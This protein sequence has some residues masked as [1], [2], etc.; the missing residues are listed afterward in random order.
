MRI[1]NNMLL[2]TVLQNLTRAQGRYL[3]IQTMASSGKRINKASDDPIGVTKDLAY[4]SSLTTI[5]Q[6]NKN[7]DQGK[8]WLTF[9]DQALGNINELLSSAKE[10]MVQMGNDTYDA[11]ARRSAAVEIEGILQ[12][13]TE[14]AN[15]QYEG[16]YIFSGSSTT[17]PPI[18]LSAIGAVYQG[19]NTNINLETEPS[20]YLRINS[21]AADFLLKAVRTLGDGFDLNAGI[22][23]NLWLSNLHGGE[24]VDMGAGIFNISTLNG[25]YNIDVSAARN[26]QDILN[27]VNNAGIPN[28]HIS[29][30][31]AQNGFTIEDTSVHQLTLNT[32]LSLLNMGRGVDQTQGLIRFAVGAGLTVDVDISAANTV[33]DVINAINTQLPAGGINNVTAALDPATNSLTI[34]DANAAPL[35][36]NISEAST[37]AHTASDLGILGDVFGTLTGKEIKTFQM[38]VTENG[39]D[40]NT[41]KTLGIQKGTEYGILNGDDL[42]SELT[43]FTKLSTLKGGQGLDLGK[44]RIVNG[45][46]F[47]DIDFAALCND[48]SATISDVLQLINSSGIN[49][50]ARINDQHTGISLFSKSEG[51]SLMVMEADDG[52]SAKDLGIFGSPDAL[53]NMIIAKRALEH[54]NSAEIQSSLATFD[55]AL[56]KVLIE[57]ADV[58]AR[59]NRAQISTSRLATFNQQVTSQLSNVEDADI[60]KVI[61]D[62]AAA[63][64]VYQSALASAAKMLQPSLIDFLK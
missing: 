59:V 5:E 22:Q 32:P 41:A 44:I 47:K 56:N 18:S 48:P 20:S 53:G 35:S 12:Q 62:M 25:E 27:T 31:E 9:S 26:I 14:A 52:H 50:E 24:G 17:K 33:G 11:S 63:E 57:R 58:G 16:N 55:E 40:Q 34:T 39:A 43:Y 23:P 36:L 1:T 46:D 54:N 10:E 6:F 51:K 19:D 21:K 42:N 28:F 15:S 2:N 3:N 7:I 4:R 61:T 37:G 38:Q 8:S 30:D 45:Q 13:I 29:I 60:T 49:V 64:S